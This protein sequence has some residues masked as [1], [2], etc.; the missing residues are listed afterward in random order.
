MEFREIYDAIK[1][2]NSSIDDIL[3]NIGETSNFIVMEKLL[4]MELEGIIKRDIS[5]GY[6]V[7]E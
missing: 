4:N 1:N 3:E 6:V 7:V 5:G 2:G